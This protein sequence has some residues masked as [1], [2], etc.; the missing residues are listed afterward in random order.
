M[1]LIWR[2]HIGYWKYFIVSDSTIIFIRNKFKKNN[3]NLDFKILRPL[4]FCFLIFI[5]WFS[6]NISILGY[7]LLNI[8]LP[9]Y[10]FALLVFFQ[11]P[12][13]LLGQ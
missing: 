8:D 12:E 3:L 4:N 13:G 9:K 6:S 7:E 1:E 5:I 10:L 11:L 2:F